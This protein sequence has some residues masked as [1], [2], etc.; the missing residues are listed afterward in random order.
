MN[1][2]ISHHYRLRRQKT[3]AAKAAAVIVISGLSDGLADPIGCD[4]AH[5]VAH[6]E[7]RV[8]YRRV[9]VAEFVGVDKLVFALEVG[10]EVDVLDSPVALYVLAVVKHIA[11]G[12]VELVFVVVLGLYRS[13]H[14]VIFIRVAGVHIDVDNRI[15]IDDTT[16]KRASFFIGVVVDAAVTGHRLKIYIEWY[17]FLSGSSGFSEILKLDLCMNLLMIVIDRVLYIDTRCDLI[18]HRRITADLRLYG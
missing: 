13:A 10:V 5:A 14:G 4:Y 3:A 15:V 18:T 1:K 11:D 7:G 16:G 8:H 2:V 9:A 6:D 17:M 12:S